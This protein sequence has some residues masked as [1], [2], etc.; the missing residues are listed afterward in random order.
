MKKDESS[1]EQ[2]QAVISTEANLYMI[3]KGSLL[4]EYLY[5]LIRSTR[6]WDPVTAA[7]TFLELGALRTCV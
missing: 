3:V 5:H 2:E 4:R 7:S 1:L 6:I